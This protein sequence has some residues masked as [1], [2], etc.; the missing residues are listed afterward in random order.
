MQTKN[1]YLYHSKDD[2]VVPFSALEKFAR[3]LPL[4]YTRIFEDR[5][6][7]NQSE[8]PELA[9]DILKVSS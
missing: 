5:K 8:F 7:I 2:P 3:A 6:H 4:A 9:E 1:I